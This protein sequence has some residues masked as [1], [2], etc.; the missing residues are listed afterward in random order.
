MQD[1]KLELGAVSETVT[2]SEAGQTQVETTSI[3]LGTTIND[4]TILN[5]PL[6]GR[7]FDELQQL[8]PERSGPVGR[9]GRRLRHGNYATNGSQP[10]QN[11]Y[12][13]NGTDNNDLPLNQVQIDP[14]P[15]AVA[16]F[17]M[18]TGTFN[19]EYGRNSGAIVNV[20]I[21]SGTNN[22][23]G[24]GFDFYR[25]TSLN[26]RRLLRTGVSRSSTP[27]SVWRHDRRPDLEKSHVH[28]S[29]S[30][31]GN[32]QRLAGNLRRSADA[33]RAKPTRPGSR[34]LSAAALFSDLATS[35]GVSATPLVGDNG[36]TFPRRNRVLHHLFQRHHTR[37]RF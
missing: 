23:H 8:E 30:Y 17:K 28:I 1:I 29:F 31:E 9:A 10:D 20:I 2:V 36:A 12:L 6:N 7:N 24:D 11:S 32:R 18:V 3:E 33:V 25:D 22:F 13:L 27:A 5:M 14:S 4:T 15:D 35:T 19:P 37:G 34:R 16:E 21:K 26:S